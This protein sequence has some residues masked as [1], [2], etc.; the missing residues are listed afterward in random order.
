MNT[1]I[2][3][4]IIEEHNEAL[5]IWIQCLQNGIIDKNGNSLIHID[6]HSD[7]GVPHFNS[8]ILGINVGNAKQFTVEEIGIGAFIVPSIYLGI[9]KK[10]S[11]VKIGQNV[12]RNKLYVRSYNAQGLR[13]IMGPVN[14]EI[15]DAQRNDSD[16]KVFD[17]CLDS[18]DSIENDSSLVLDID[19]D[20]FSCTG[21]PIELKNISIEIT[22]EEHERF[23]TNPYHRVR[24]LGFKPRVHCEDGRYFLILNDYKHSYPHIHPFNLKVDFDTITS[25]VMTLIDCLKEKHIVPRVITICR[26]RYS[27]FTDEEQWWTIEHLL[28]QELS[29][30][31]PIHVTSV[32]NLSHIDV[33]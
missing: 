11:W 16:V 10:V 12:K 33:N 32:N 15:I 31:F 17:Y 27:G 23:N 29:K 21:N 26:S 24:F 28:L 2:P 5:P 20:Y 8:S 6:E 14:D 9:F 13:L 22:K 7:M 18:I 1:T 4:Y 3:T 30:I 19:L 25:R